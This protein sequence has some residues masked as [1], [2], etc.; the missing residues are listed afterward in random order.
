MKFDVFFSISQTPVDGQMPSEAA[1]FRHFFEQVIAADELG[2]ETAWV[3]ESHFSTQ[4]QKNHK[5][6]VVPHWQGEVGLNTDIFQL[7]QQVFNKTKRIETGSAVMNIV[8]NGGPLAAAEKVATFSTLHG[9]DPRE[10]RRVHLGFSA[11]RFEFMNR[12]SGI[13][14]RNELELAAW[15]ALKGKIF[16]EATEILLRLLSGET[17]SSDDVSQTWLSESDFRSQEEWQNVLKL[18]PTSSIVNGSLSVPRRWSFESTTIIPKDWRREL[19]QPVI[20]SHD[21]AAQ[22]HANRFY[23]TQVF[24]LSITAPQII[25]ETHDRMKKHYHSRGGG[26]RRDYMPRTVFVFIN[27][28]PGLS[29]EQKSLKARSEAQAALE[30]YWNALE[31]TLDPKKISGATDNALVGNAEQIADQITKRFH[32]D[33]RLMLWFDFF[34]HDSARVMENMSAFKNKVVPLIQERLKS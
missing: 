15:P 34:N 8:C 11:G 17:L 21:P 29:F 32:P 19:I 6:P 2:F 9:L 28:Q 27:E 1:M 20:G 23:P 14:P 30:A 13:V 7:S 26:W 16:I 24:N 10:K 4:T 12:V 5:H 25:N 18:A 31:G 33:D 22:T 3:A